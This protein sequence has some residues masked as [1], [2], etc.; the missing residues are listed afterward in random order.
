MMMMD[1]T[2]E[3]SSTI[4]SHPA[5]NNQTVTGITAMDTT[6]PHDV[7][8]QLAPPPTT[9]ATTIEA[10]FTVVSMDT[11]NN[12]DVINYKE[13]RK[14]KKKKREKRE[15]DRKHRDKEHREHRDREHREKDREHHHHRDKERDH[16]HREHRDKERE[17]E[18]QRGGGDY[19]HQQLHHAG[20][21]LLTTSASSSPSSLSTLS[22]SASPASC[23]S[24]S[25]G[26]CVTT[27]ATATS[28]PHNLKIR[29]LLSGVNIWNLI[30]FFLFILRNI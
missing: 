29:F 14:H 19:H 18:Q 4:N 5:S 27:N 17:R 30:F 21:P 24:S 10:A 9:N 20:Q 8:D 7:N 25:A 16:H 28:Y 1:T 11:E 3:S 22:A 15:K 2:V 23:S 6:P 13:S 26:V 12:M